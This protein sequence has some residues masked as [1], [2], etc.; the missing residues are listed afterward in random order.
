MN[1]NIFDGKWKQIRGQGKSLVGQ[2]YRRRPET[3]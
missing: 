3:S 1:N 2:T